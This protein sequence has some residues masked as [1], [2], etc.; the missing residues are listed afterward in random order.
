MSACHWKGRKGPLAWDWTADLGYRVMCLSCSISR[1][2]AGR[3]KREENNDSVQGPELSQGCFLKRGRAQG[4]GRHQ[5]KFS[6]EGNTSWE[7]V[8]GTS[9][10]SLT[11]TCAGWVVGLPSGHLCKSRCPSPVFKAVLCS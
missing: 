1:M 3:E 2:F 8:G 11:R 7:S 10:P 6:E 9:E 5:G 4:P